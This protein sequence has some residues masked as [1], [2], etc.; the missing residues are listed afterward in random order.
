MKIV[1]KGFLVPLIAD[2]YLNLKNSKWRIQYGEEVDLIK[3]Y[4]H[5]PPYWMRHFEFFAHMQPG[6]R[7]QNGTTLRGFCKRFIVHREI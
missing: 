7:N 3:F 1:T 5:Q 4:K 6:N 2:I